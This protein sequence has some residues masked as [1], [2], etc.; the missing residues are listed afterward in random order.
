[1]LQDLLFTTTGIAILYF[2]AELL[3]KGSITLSY[4][5][6]VQPLLVGL[7]VIG[8]GTSSPELVV[9]IVAAIS[10]R[11][12]IAVGNIIG[13]NISNFALILGLGAL[14]YPVATKKS[15]LRIELPV[16]IA[17][18]LLVTLLTLNGLLSRWN[19]LLLLFGLVAYLFITIRSNSP[20][21][22]T[23]PDTID[24]RA[25]TGVMLLRIGV[26]LVFLIAGAELMISGLTG[27]A[28]LFQ[29]SEAVIGLTAVAVG[30][31]LP[32]LATTVVAGVRKQ[33]DLILGAL[34]GSNILNLLF[35][36]GVTII[37]RPITLIDITLSDLIIMTTLAVIIVPIIRTGYVVSRLEGVFLLII[38]AGYI[39]WLFM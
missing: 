1:M 3:I 6:R 33:G 30:T 32:E 4:K 20:S 27:L 31:S 25:S 21:V 18:S 17:T 14:I 10:D 37:I 2:G 13:S 35:V 5:Y 34:I 29:L 22:F 28:R 8:L 11:G 16:L 26:G 23:K 39:A 15:L 24:T 19:G 7:L 36:L 12:E 9:S 38:Y